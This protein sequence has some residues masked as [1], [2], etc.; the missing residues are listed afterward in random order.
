MKLNESE[1]QISQQQV[2]VDVLL[3]KY[4]KGDETSV[5]EV[6][7][8]VAKALAAVETGDPTSADCA[9]GPLSST[10]AAD[11]LEEDRRAT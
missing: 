11:R 10:L 8:R 5:D 6:R 7:R 4:A 3:E 1:F 2:S 9:M